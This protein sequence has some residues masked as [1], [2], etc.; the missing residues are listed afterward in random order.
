M[1]IH[2]LSESHKGQSIEQDHIYILCQGH[3][4]KFKQETDYESQIFVKFQSFYLLQNS[5][6][7]LR[8]FPGQ[9]IKRLILKGHTPL[10]LLKI[11]LF[12]NA[13]NHF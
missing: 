7:M 13:P 12:G 5:T 8:L 10:N 2:L 9:V 6:L 11:I 1:Y 4:I 3:R